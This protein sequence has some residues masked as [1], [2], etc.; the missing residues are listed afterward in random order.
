MRLAKPAS[1]I[2]FSVIAALLH[3]APIAR[4]NQYAQ[5]L[6]VSFVQHIA[7]DQPVFFVTFRR[8]SFQQ[9]SEPTARTTHC[10]SDH[11]IASSIEFLKTLYGFPLMLFASA[12]E[13][14]DAAIALFR[15]D[16]HGKMRIKMIVKSFATHRTTLQ[17]PAKLTPCDIIWLSFLRFN[18]PLTL[19]HHRLILFTILL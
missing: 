6:A 19:F 7:S 4:R 2:A 3:F 11:R 16:G 1:L 5:T 9:R 17:H 8:A 10:V 18:L 14:F 12:Q 15:H 13:F